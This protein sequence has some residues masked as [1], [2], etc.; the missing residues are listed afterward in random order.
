MIAMTPGECNGPRGAVQRIRKTAPRCLPNPQI[1]CCAMLA[2]R[3]TAVVQEKRFL[4]NRAPAGQPPDPLRL[5]RPWERARGIDG[6]R[7]PDGPKRGCVSMVW[8]RRITSASSVIP[9]DMV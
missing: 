7:V 4:G 6:P 3:K 8:R 1:P 2:N 9:S 5:P